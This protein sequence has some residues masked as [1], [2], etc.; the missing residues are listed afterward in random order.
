MASEGY[1]PPANDPGRTPEEIAELVEA[2]NRHA[3]ALVLLAAE[4]ARRGVRATTQ[5][6]RE[7]MAGLERKHPGE[8]ERSLYASLELSLRRLP[9]PVRAAL[10]P[11]GVVQGGGQLFVLA[12]VMGVESDAAQETGAALIGVGLAEELDYGYLRLDPALPAYLREQMSAEER[13]AAQARWAEAVESLVDF[14]YEQRSQ[15]ARLAAQLTLL[16]LPNLLAFLEW[17]GEHLAAE[18]AVDLAGS[19]EELLAPLG[20]PQALARAVQ[21][22]QAAAAGLGEWSHA[23][24]EAGR[25]AVERLLDAG[26]LQAASGAAQILLERGRAAGEAAYPEAAY[27]LAVAHFMLGRVLT[28][29]GAAQ[30][31]LGPLAEAQRRFEA[32]AGAGNQVQRDGFGC[33]HRARRLLEDLGRLEE[34]AGAYLAAIQLDE[35]AGRVRDV[36]IGKFRSAP[37]ACTRSATRKRWKPTMKPWGPSSAWESRAW[38]LTPGTRPAWCTGKPGSTKP[39]SGLT[40]RRWPSA[41]STGCAVMKPIV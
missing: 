40:A 13:G 18:R 23:R 11:L 5:S 38:W 14:L 4:I 17:A 35:K 32:L 7:L 2:A 28:R 20:R 24:F 22:R 12:S 34:A 8:R 1:S 25:L 6:L 10:A 36:A 3:R 39:P 33:H 31:V 19:I 21:L 9:E 16:E 29:G 27:D 37:Y 30:Q 15:D 26:Q 41:C